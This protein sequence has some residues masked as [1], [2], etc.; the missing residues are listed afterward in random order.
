VNVGAASREVVKGLQQLG[1]QLEGDDRT[2]IHI[3]VVET[4]LDKLYPIGTKT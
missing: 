1:Q 4:A 3:Q 2:T